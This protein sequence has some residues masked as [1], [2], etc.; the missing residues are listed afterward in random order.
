MYFLKEYWV[1]LFYVM[2]ELVFGADFASKTRE[3]MRRIYKLE[4]ILDVSYL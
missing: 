3:E 4:S 2:E 1:Q